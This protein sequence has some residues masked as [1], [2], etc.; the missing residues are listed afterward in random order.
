M[1]AKIWNIAWKDLYVTYT[2]RNLIL[3]MLIT[4]LALATIIGSAFSGFI[5]TSGNDVPISD[6]PVALVNF[7]QG[8][9]AN[10]EML[11]QGD[12]FVQL[13]VPPADA[14]EEQLE[15]NA[16]F[17]LTDT[18]LLTDADQARDGVASGEYAAAIIIPP[19]FSAN[20]TYTQD[21]PTLETAEI[22]LLV[23]E[24]AP[25]SAV[26]MRSVIGAI[27]NQISTGSITIAATIDTLV[28]M[29]VQ[30]P[31]FG[32]EFAAA[33]LSGDFQPDFNPAFDSSSSPL[34][35]DQ[36]TIAGE[37]VTSFNPLVVFGSAQAVFFMMFTAM[38][39]ANSILEEKR[40]GTLQRLV[41][42]PTPRM[43]ILLGKLLATFLN[44]WVQIILLFAA[45]T[46][47][48]SILTGQIDFIWGDNFPA[49]FAVVFA[50]AFAASGLGTL[51]MS[52]VK[53][54]EQGNVI[55]SIIS[56]SFGVLGGAFFNIQAIPFLASLSRITLNYWGVD[57]F[58]QLALGQADILPNLT[59]LLAFGA[60]TFVV[61][62]IMFNRRLE[63]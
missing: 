49:L 38:G 14:T 5:G 44:C 13:L 43:T 47:V 37:S 27:G 15:S 52:L 54:A 25:T 33:S 53:T 8:V 10:G 19:D 51:A 6:I 7:D 31:A 55:G 59:F 28:E 58:T 62:L 61:G 16:L 34:A 30:D 41:I 18:V 22:E 1:L 17:Q 50:T 11:N 35:I 4:P 24:A 29:A 42:S 56:L 26:I 21:R 45:L 60:V 46:F 32:L 63:F 57:A 9:Q 20:I 36:Q 48:G 40:D 39:T 3:I 2:D 23:T 12:I